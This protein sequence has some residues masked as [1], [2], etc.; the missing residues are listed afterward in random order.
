MA[1]VILQYDFHG[2]FLPRMDDGSKSVAESVQMLSCAA[3]QGIMAMAATPHYYRR[4]PV[5]EFIGRRQEAWELLQ[6]AAPENSPQVVLGAEVAIRPGLSR[7]PE[8]DKLCLGSSPYILLEMPWTGWGSDEVRQVQDI[9]CARGL[10][11]IMAHT[12]RYLALGIAKWPQVEELLSLGVLVQINGDSLQ[13]FSGRRA[14]GRLWK[15]GAVHLLGSDCHR[16]E[17]RPSGL[18]QASKYLQTHK[19]TQLTQRAN[20]LGQEIFTQA[21]CRN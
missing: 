9:S 7:E 2:H 13:S 20:A 6:K 14:V 8:L 16:M 21:A 4:E 3:N 12:E 15:R 11:P 10:S 17:T 5:E 19:M 1:F 18:E